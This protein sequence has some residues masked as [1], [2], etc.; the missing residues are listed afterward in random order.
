MLWASYW[1]TA[2]T[3]ASGSCTVC[4]TYTATSWPV[5]G[6]LCEASNPPR[7]CCW[8]SAAAPPSQRCLRCSLFVHLCSGTAAVIFA[9][10]L[11]RLLS[12]GAFCCDQGWPMRFIHVGVGAACLLG[13]FAAVLY[14][15][16]RLVQFVRTQLLP[17]YTKKRT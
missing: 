1:Q 7:C 11:T 15:E 13:V 14:S 6:N 17:R 8:R 3:W 9:S 2:L 12:Q 16:S 10:S 5:H 4:F